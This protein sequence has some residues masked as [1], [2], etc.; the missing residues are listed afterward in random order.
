MLA[1]ALPPS[2]A[3]LQPQFYAKTPRICAL[4]F[5]ETQLAT[6]ILDFIRLRLH[7]LQQMDIW[8]Q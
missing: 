1:N 4:I 6:D 3:L 8:I 7:T 2:V 5:T